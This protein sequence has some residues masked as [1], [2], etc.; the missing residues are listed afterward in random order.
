MQIRLNAH[1]TFIVLHIV[2]NIKNIGIKAQWRDKN[3]ALIIKSYL[4]EG[5]FVDAKGVNYVSF[6]IVHEKK[7]LTHV[8]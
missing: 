8:F 4:F 6:E 7:Y 1:C 5:I 2:G 3:F